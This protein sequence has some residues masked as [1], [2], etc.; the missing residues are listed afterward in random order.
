MIP[1]YKHRIA[2]ERRTSSTDRTISDWLKDTTSDLASPAR[3]RVWLEIN[4][5]YAQAV[6]GRLNAGLPLAE[7]EAAALAELGDP[8]AAANQ[9]R[10]RHLTASEDERIERTLKNYRNLV[11]LLLSFAVPGLMLW[12][13]PRGA[14]IP[15]FVGMAVAIMWFGALVRAV[16]FSIARFQGRK[17]NIRILLI[18]VTLDDLVFSPL[19]CV[20]LWLGFGLGGPAIWAG[21]VVMWVF[22]WVGGAIRTFPYLLLLFKL[23]RVTDVHQELPPRGASVA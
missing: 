23:S 1:G 7:A 18:A 2:E 17:A 14:L 16:G 19:F 10:K 21:G 13:L 11:Y 9:F 15:H 20:F 6:E 8:I 5:H 4:T 3:D 12:I 22:M